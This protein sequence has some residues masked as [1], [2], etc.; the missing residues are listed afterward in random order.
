MGSNL[1]RTDSGAQSKQKIIHQL[2]PLP[3][4]FSLVVQVKKKPYLGHEV[5]M[6]MTDPT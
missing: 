5:K 2:V 3:S 4:P 6:R 1:A